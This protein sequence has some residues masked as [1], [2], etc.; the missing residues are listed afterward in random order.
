MESKKT[1]DTAEI[2]VLIRHIV[3][4]TSVQILSGPCAVSDGRYDYTRRGIPAINPALYTDLN[5]A[6]IQRNG[7]RESKKAFV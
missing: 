4:Y 6:D 1:C 5:V 2:I 3:D 7:R